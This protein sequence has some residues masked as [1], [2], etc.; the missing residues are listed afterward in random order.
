MNV[1]MKGYMKGYMEKLRHT[2]WFHGAMLMFLVF[3]ASEL[4]ANDTMEVMV[5]R[6]PKAS[7][8]QL[9]AATNRTDLDPAA[10]VA[11]V[12]QMVKAGRVT[13]VFR[14]A[15]PLGGQISISDRKPPLKIPD[16]IKIP[17]GMDLMFEADKSEAGLYEVAIAFKL[18]A[19]TG[20]KYESSNFG[21]RNI[22]VVRPGDWIVATQWEIADSSTLLLMRVDGKMDDS[23]IVED[24]SNIETSFELFM[25][26]EN[27]AAKFLKSGED[28]RSKAVDWFHAQAE[29]L[30][31]ITMPSLPSRDVGIRLGNDRIIDEN[32]WTTVLGGV[33]GSG[34]YRLVDIVNQ[35]ADLRL[36]LKW[37][38]PDTKTSEPGFEFKQSVIVKDSLTEMVIPT[39]KNAVGKDMVVALVTSK[40]LGATAGSSA[41]AQNSEAL[42]TGKASRHAIGEGKIIANYA[43]PVN[44][45]H[46]L[47]RRA[48][49]VIVNMENPFVHVEPTIKDLVNANG[50]RLRE[51]DQVELVRGMKLHVSGAN[52]AHDIIEFLIEMCI[53]ES[54]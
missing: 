44:F 30:A 37:S 19:P 20:K 10:F 34:K 51:S 24:V 5:L 45:I 16:D 13:E 25:T 35:M 1:I 11:G 3:V 52:E 28:T 9:V 48:G 39:K 53:N 31:S 42:E 26:T 6:A 15:R 17:M 27:D 8:D 18:A 38:A 49:D 33:D 36:D 54:K 7:A 23:K 46:W 29:K 2:L 22:F 21:C 12:D 43:I 40:N 14:G 47:E 4:R 41:D 32:G 50:S